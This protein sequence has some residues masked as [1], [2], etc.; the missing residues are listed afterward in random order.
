MAPLLYEWVGEKLQQLREWRARLMEREDWQP[1]TKQQPCGRSALELV[2]MCLQTVDSLFEM[3][4][5][6]PAELVRTMLLGVDESIT[7]Y[8]GVRGRVGVQG[9]VV[10]CEGWGSCYM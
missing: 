6:L 8:G 10:G 4:L 9:G 1:V 5:Q 3:R 7:K 2:R